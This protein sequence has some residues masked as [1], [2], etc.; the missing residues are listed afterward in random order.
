ML[1][2]QNFDRRMSR[3]GLALIGCGFLA[4]FIVSAAANLNRLRPP[5]TLTGRQ[6]YASTMERRNRKPIVRRATPERSGALLSLIPADLAESS[7]KEKTFVYF[8]RNADLLVKIGFSKN[9][10]RRAMELQKG[11]PYAIEVLCSTKGGSELEKHFHELFKDQHQ[12]GEWFSFCGAVKR[13][14]DAV[15][16]TCAC[17]SQ[18]RLEG[19]QEKKRV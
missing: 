9:V 6:R 7:R 2:G 12:F 17:H 1:Q 19:K 3:L 15:C 14:L 5:P 10:R 13:F 4:Q 16:S 8:I 11:Q 18:L